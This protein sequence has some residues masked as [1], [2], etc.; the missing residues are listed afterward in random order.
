MIDIE[1]IQATI[2]REIRGKVETAHTDDEHHYKYVPTGEVYPSTTTRSS[3]IAMP[4]LKDWAA[5][6]TANHIEQE[7]RAGGDIDWYELKKEAKQ[8]HSEVL[9]DA[10]TIGSIGHDAIEEYL[11]A[12]LKKGKEP[13]DIRDFLEWEEGYEDDSR[14]YAIVRS[15]KQFIDDFHVQPIAP[16]MKVVNEKH[17][18]GGMLDLLAIAGEIKKPGSSD[19][20]HTFMTYSHSRNI[21]ECSLCGRRVKKHLTLIDWK[22]SNSVMKPKYSM[23]VASYWYAL[24]E[25][26]DIKPTKIMIVQLSKEKKDYTVVEPTHR[27]SAFKAFRDIGKV[28]DWL[29]DGEDKLEKVDK[30][31]QVTLFGSSD[32]D[33]SGLTEV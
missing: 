15:A 22:T 12:W 24:K 7:V 9:D 10:G 3:I 4:Y 2:E 28:Y 19:C 8:R 32:D 26:A 23:Q 1:G 20:D 30:K 6:L 11:I 29:N 16:E 18:Y 31:K 14:G 33:P 17:S 5:K 13:D 25:M 21:D 27:P